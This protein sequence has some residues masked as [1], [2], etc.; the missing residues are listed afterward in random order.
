MSY[1]I[2]NLTH[3]S[4]VIKTFATENPGKAKKSRGTKARI[5]SQNPDEHK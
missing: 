5:I 2:D 4:F 1:L 3:P